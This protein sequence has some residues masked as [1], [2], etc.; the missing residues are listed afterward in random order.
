MRQHPPPMTRPAAA[1]K[2]GA[3]ARG[4]RAIGRE[5]PM[6]LSHRSTRRAAALAVMLCAAAAG[7]GS[8]AAQ[9]ELKIGY[10]KHPVQDASIDVMESWAKANGVKITRVAMPYEIFM[11]K[12]TATL[13]SGGDQFDVIWHNDDWGQL[14]KGWVEPTD[15]IP[16]MAKTFK[17]TVDV[18]F[19][20]DDK[21]PTVV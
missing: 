8:A 15:D 4:R 10:M 6:T 1:T 7:P 3:E 19:L 16:G 11:E 18:A 13:T 9:T 21:R 20:N 5:M 14:W 12:V 2:A 17:R